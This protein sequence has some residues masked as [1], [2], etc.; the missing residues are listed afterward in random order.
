MLQREKVT[1]ATQKY[2]A[3]IRK[4]D[5]KLSVRGGDKGGGPKEHA[6]EVTI[7]TLRN[8]VVCAR[9]PGAVSCPKCCSL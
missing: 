5:V 3:A 4:V 1:K 7:F 8:G 6:A 2:E 9:L